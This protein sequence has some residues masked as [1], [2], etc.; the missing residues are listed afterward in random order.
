MGAR[1]GDSRKLSP[2]SRLKPNASSLR[3]L[4]LDDSHSPFHIISHATSCAR[5]TIRSS[6]SET[7]RRY[8]CSAAGCKVPPSST[9]W[10]PT[11]LSS[12]PQNERQLSS[13]TAIRRINNMSL[14]DVEYGGCRIAVSHSDTPHWIPRV[15]S[16]YQ[17]SN[18]RPASLSL[19]RALFAHGAHSEALRAAVRYQQ[20]S[21]REPGTVWS[22]AML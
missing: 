22:A 3:T 21:S 15:Q 17:L 11:Q 2:S 8:Y 20:A 14:H 5:S 13:H 4:C 6:C 10:Y 12:W 9:T 19:V 16:V 7:R 18:H 1:S